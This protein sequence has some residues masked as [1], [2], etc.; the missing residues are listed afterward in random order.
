M[1]KL[2]IEWSPA[3]HSLKEQNNLLLAM[4]LRLQEALLSQVHSKS[5]TRSLMG[6]VTHPINQFRFHEVHYVL[7]CIG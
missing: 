6:E 1:K 7:V 4:I 3:F 2:F 5:L